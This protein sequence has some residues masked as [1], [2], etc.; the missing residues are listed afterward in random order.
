MFEAARANREDLDPDR[1]SFMTCLRVARRITIMP[2]V[3]F[4]PRPDHAL[5][6]ALDELLA[7][8]TPPR[9]P[10]S[11]PRT[12]NA[13][14]RA[15][16]SRNLRSTALEPCPEPSNSSHQPLKLTV[17]DLEHTFRRFKQTLGWTAPKLRSPQAADRWTWLVLAAH[18]QLR[19]ARPLAEDLRKPWEPPAKPGRLAPAR[20]RRGFLRLHGKTPQ[21]AGAPKT[22][23]A[24][25]G[26]PVGSK[27][28][29]RAH[30]HLV[31]KQ[32]KADTRQNGG[33]K[34]AT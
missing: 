18:T 21:P 8:L 10:R 25:P 31:G 27:N 9:R 11:N 5:A 28:K 4:P 22:G 33:T 20:V 6:L 26:R 24:G 32:S 23:T 30:Q 17:L 1:L 14:S 19:V 2:P 12:S 16:E 34:Q 15:T 29:R 13:S 7:N 3:A